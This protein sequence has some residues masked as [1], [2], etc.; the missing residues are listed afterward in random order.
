MALA[1]TSV[2][3]M[4]ASA[5][6]SNVNG[7][8]FNPANASFPTDYT[9]TSATGNAPVLSSASYSFV[10]GDVGAW[11]Y[12]KAGTN[13]L[14]G[15]YQISSVAGGAAT[16]NA[17]IGAAVRFT[18]AGN[19]VINTTAGVAS[20]AS[21]T[22]G[23]VG[24]DYSQQDAAE[25]AL[26]GLTSAGVGAIILTASSTVSMIGNFI[27]IASGTNFTAGFYEIASVSAGVSLTTD[28]DCTSGVGADGVAKV[29]G[30]LVNVTTAFS[31]TP[32]SGNH[33]WIKDGDYAISAS[34]GGAAGSNS[35][36]VTWE[37]Y[38]SIRSDGPTTVATMPKLTFAGGTG[39][40][41]SGSRYYFKHLNMEGDFG[42]TILSLAGTLNCAYRCRVV[43]A[44]SNPAAFGIIATGSGV[45]EC[46]VSSPGGTAIAPD[47]GRAQIVGCYI[48]D[49]LYGIITSQTSNPLTVVGNVFHNN[50]TADLAF[51]A[52]NNAPTLI[53]GNT[54]YGNLATPAGIGVSFGAAFSET[55]ILLNNIF[56]GKT[57]GIAV[58]TG[59]TT[60]IIE[61][62][63]NFFGNTANSSGY[64]VH[65][66][67]TFLDPEFVDADNG[68]FAIGTNLRGLARPRVFPGELSESISDLGAV[69]SGLGG[70]SGG[71]GSGTS[72]LGFTGFGLG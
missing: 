22:G 63:N 14:P 23:T 5:A 55:M 21:P 53:M 70:S 36:A 7:G 42:G 50:T 16:V 68:N 65:G 19:Y 8:G 17:T 57:T 54:F 37:G 45:I 47:S 2:Y 33:I 20:V 52:A 71:G 29:G 6:A 41:I 43:N 15:W 49:S 30:A 3:Q 69:Q 35:F 1:A 51:G 24:V 9:A 61:E 39:W 11:V 66:S 27:N 32:I 64:T 25:F 67:A 62:Y 60:A 26:T 38:S 18:V 56:C 58:T 72:K 10:A 4:Q 59:S 40:A 48:Y 46:E 12:V 44:S 34:L 31:T 28:R 13:W